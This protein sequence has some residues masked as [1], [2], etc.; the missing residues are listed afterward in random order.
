MKALQI[1]M[2]VRKQINLQRTKSEMRFLSDN[3]FFI[4]FVLNN[5]HL[6]KGDFPS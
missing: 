1:K 5:F 3:V 2:N 6:N 4:R